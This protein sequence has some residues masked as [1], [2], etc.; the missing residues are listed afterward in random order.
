MT[1]GELGRDAARPGPRQDGRVAAPFR[2]RNI[3]TLPRTQEIAHD[4]SGY[5]SSVRV[6]ARAELA[7]SCEFIDYAEVP[8]GSSIGDHRHSAQEEE[9]YLVLGGAGTMRLEAGTVAVTA[10]DLIRNP[11]GG[12]HGLTN[13]GGEVLRLFI[14]ALT[15]PL[16]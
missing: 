13:T 4:G 15:L 5:I 10:G 11:A 16:E 7:G 1:Q 2:I 9:Y 8:P 12:L 6:A 3:L 14:F